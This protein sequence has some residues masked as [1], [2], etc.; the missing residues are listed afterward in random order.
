MKKNNYIQNKQKIDKIL[1]AVKNAF[2]AFKNGFSL[3]KTSDE[4]LKI[5][6]LS[7]DNELGEYEILYDYIWGDDTAGIEG[8][9]ENYSP[10]TGDTVIMDISVKHDGVWCDVT[11]TFFVG[12][13]SVKHVEVFEML[14]QS[15]KL[16]ENALKNGIS[17][18]DVFNAVNSVYLKNGY[19]LVHHA[20]HQ[21]LTE[22]VMQPQFL[23]ENVNGFIENGKFYTLEPGL[24]LNFGI[25]LEND[26]L[27]TDN[28]VINLFEDLMP[29]NIKE[30][31]LK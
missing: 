18:S 9:T 12:E 10:K 13:P 6:T 11:R 27:V 8:K 24:Y 19:S 3:D 30:Y 25:R 20:G 17:A 14:K 5:F 22:P 15:I 2:N 28:G 29:L 26:Y 23:K 1:T 7:L 21:I 4:L 16:G 31:I